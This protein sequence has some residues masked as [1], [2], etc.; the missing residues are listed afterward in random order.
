M[1]E[2]IG[3]VEILAPRSYP[4]DPEHPRAREGT[5]MLVE[6][7]KYPLY[8][9]G[10]TYYWVMTGRRN[11]LGVSRS[12][13]GIFVVARNDA[14]A[15][16]ELTFASRRRG[17]DEWAELLADDTSVEGSPGQRLRITLAEDSGMG[18][19]VPDATVRPQTAQSVIDRA[20]DALYE[21][22]AA[23]FLS[24]CRPMAE[25]LAKGGL[26]ATEAPAPA[27]RYMLV[28]DN[29][30]HHYVIEA[31]R[32]GEWFMLDD[33]AINAGPP[34]A[35]QV[36]GSPTLVTFTDP[37]IDGDPIADVVTGPSRMPAE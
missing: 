18:E 31:E 23:W 36:G 4:L 9:E 11:Q 8:R 12:G 17:P 5:W 34:W 7:G 22:E 15:G 33:D 26:L 29:N 24:E 14:P 19:D 27:K 37:V 30:R 16:P 28:D 10:I 3:T 25:N 32:E 20:A 21:M 2:Q 13:D 1:H 35:Y 6:P